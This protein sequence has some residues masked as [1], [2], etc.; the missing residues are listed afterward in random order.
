[1][2]RLL[3]R[4]ILLLFVIP[5]LSPGC[6]RGPAPLVPSPV[7]TSI[8]DGSYELVPES[9]FASVQDGIER[10]SEESERKAFERI[11]SSNIDQFSN[12]SIDHGV[13]RSGSFI[14]QE[15]SLISAERSENRLLGRAIW[16]EDVGDPGDM[17]EVT[18]EMRRQGNTLSFWIYDPNNNRGDAIVLSRI[19]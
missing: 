14:V 18:I 10:S 16:H 12:F 4:R 9:S 11:L 17:N 5:F 1:M 7:D 8:F 2:T 13:I 6:I 3:D 15:F 19:E